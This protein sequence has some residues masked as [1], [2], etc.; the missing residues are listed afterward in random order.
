MRDLCPGSVPLKT[1]FLPSAYRYAIHPDNDAQVNIPVEIRFSNYQISNGIKFPFHIQRFVNGMPDLDI[2]VTSVV[3]NS[4]LT[5][6][7]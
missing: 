3:I 1:T 5:I 4:D 6:S 2:T 7:K